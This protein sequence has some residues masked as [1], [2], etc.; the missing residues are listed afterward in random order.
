MKL[1]TAL[2]LGSF[3]LLG[4]PGAGRAEVVDRSANGFQVKTV[5]TLAAPPAKVYDA[6]VRSVGQWWDPEHTFSGDAGNLSLAAEPGGC[7]CEKLPDG[8][9]IRHATVIY[10][11]PGQKLVLSGAFGPLQTSGASGSLTWDLAKIETGTRL[12]MQYSVGGYFPGGFQA[13]TDPV[14][15][16][17]GTQV[18]RLKSFVELGKPAP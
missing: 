16:V 15:L 11:A 7:F 10:A 5:V 14:D 8:G 4:L 9:G 3:A 12:T 2:A 6:L 17:L 13:V 1:R 18:R